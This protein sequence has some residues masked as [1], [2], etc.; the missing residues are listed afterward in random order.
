MVR[1]YFFL[2][3]I[4]VFLITSLACNKGNGPT[5]PQDTTNPQACFTH[6]A[7]AGAVMG[8]NVVFNA[9]CSTGGLFAITSYTWNW[10]D[11]SGPQKTT[12]PEAVHAFDEPGLLEVGLVVTNAAG[13][14]ANAA[15]ELAVVPVGSSPTACFSSDSP[16]G[17]QP[18]ST[19]TFDASCSTD[20]DGDELEFS[21][22]WGDGT[23][24]GPTSDASA[25]HEFPYEG[26]FFVRLTVTDSTG[27]ETVSDAEEFSI[28]YPVRLELITSTDA[29]YARD[30]AFVKNYVY[31]LGGIYTTFEKISGLLIFEIDGSGEPILIGEA[32]L[33]SVGIQLEVM[34]GYAYVADRHA[35]LVIF[36]I[37]NP[38]EP[39]I[40][41]SADT[42]TTYGME[43]RDGYVYMTG[44]PQDAYAWL[45]IVDVRDPHYP[46]I[47]G[48]EPSNYT[49]SLIEVIGDYAYAS[50]YYIGSGHLRTLWIADI[51]DPSAPRAAGSFV[52]NNTLIDVE[53]MGGY[54]CA[55][56]DG[57]PQTLLIVLDVSQ[58][59]KPFEIS[60]M[61]L[62]HA[63]DLEVMGSYAYIA[64]VTD[65]LVVVDLSNPTD[66]RI[67][68]QLQA[69][70][71][72]YHV[73]VSGNKAFLASDISIGFSYNWTYSLIQLW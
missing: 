41:G 10:G 63:S 3:L 60:S 26:E 45:T 46:V 44:D 32:F 17:W 9:G 6:D 37:S 12:G 56:T 2:A 22:D 54:L 23:T 40:T 66:P 59:D 27:W 71:D 48:A 52:F 15:V 57:H 7:P 72:T 50:K 43:I 68:S 62:D 21:W 30:I 11:G 20:P 24:T 42:G 19:I 35:G 4:A 65:D 70:G 1:S 61:G 25:T 16:E 58:P 49:A 34:D 53:S 55:L 47:V 13:M 33:P 73:A 51:S 14:K 38:E 69:P 67:F 31:V 28:G 18:G 5:A 36:D 39:F 8:E 64:S 29:K